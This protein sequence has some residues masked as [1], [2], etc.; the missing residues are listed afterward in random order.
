MS[1]YCETTGYG[2]AP[3]DFSCDPSDFDWMYYNPKLKTIPIFG[4]RKRCCSCGEFCK[5]GSE[6]GLISRWRAVRSEVEE[7]I[8][9]EDGEVTIA[10]WWYCE[11]CMDLHSAVTDLGF[12]YNIGDDLRELVKVEY[13]AYR[14]YMN[15]KECNQ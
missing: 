15:G 1:L 3:D 9:G 11:S 14:E 12:G 8:H 4:K 2:D 10:D 6:G 13:K 5:P 7:K